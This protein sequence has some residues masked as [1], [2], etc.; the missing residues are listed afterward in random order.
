MP[1]DDA[2]LDNICNRL[3]LEIEK[4]RKETEVLKNLERVAR[5]IVKIPDPDDN[6][7]M[8]LPDDKGLGTRMETARRQK[9]YDSVLAEATKLGI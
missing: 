6:S 4:K 2:N 3:N 7:T 5:S 9:I 8:I 1:V